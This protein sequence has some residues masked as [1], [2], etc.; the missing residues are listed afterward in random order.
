M[1]GKYH[2]CRGTGT[3]CK[4]SP[5]R[6]R[7]SNHAGKQRPPADTFGTEIKGTPISERRPAVLAARLGLRRKNRRSGIFGLFLHAFK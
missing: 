1:P 2:L 6:N 3:L 5:W 7:P 4:S